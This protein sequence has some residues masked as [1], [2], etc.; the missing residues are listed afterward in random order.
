[1]VT[2]VVDTMRNMSDFNFSEVASNASTLF[3]DS[4]SK[5]IN[6]MTSKMQYQSDQKMSGLEKE[7]S[8]AQTKK[9]NAQKNYET[10]KGNYDKA[11]KNYKKAKK[12]KDKSKYSSEMKKY[13]KQMN[14][15]KKQ[16]NDYKKLVSEQTEFNN[17]YQE[18]SSQMISEFSS[19]LSEYQTKA[20]TLIDDTING[21]TDTYQAKYDALI[22]K[23]DTLIS[24][25]KSAGDLFEISN[26]GIMTVND[27]KEQTQN[28][29]DY[30]DKL[31][32]IKNKVS[33]E[34]FDQIASYDMDQGSAFMDRLLAMS[35][36][37]LKAYS[38]AY[39]EKM[40]VSEESAK[41]IYSKDF[42]N[43]ANDYKNSLDAAFK[44]LPKELETLGQQTMKGFVNGLTK[45]TDYMTKAIQTMVQAMVDQFK[46]DLDIHSPSKVTEGL[47][48]FTGQGF[49]NGLL[50]SIRRVQKDAR[51]FINS[52]TSP[53]GDYT[54]DIGNVRRTVGANNNRGSAP[55]TQ[56]VVNNYN[57]VQNNTSPK[58][59]SAL[60]TY[61]AR[62]QQVNMLKA[63]TT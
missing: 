33:S 49:G 42:D 26:A 24:K 15:Y 62:R 57:L 29:R 12:T 27:I 53:I 7:L 40:R 3:S 39:D 20:Q 46:S 13:Q 56:T 61:R 22:E 58:S 6:Y 36:A 16:T 34:L 4:M 17:A 32:T 35:D 5:Q 50:E 28:I 45:N 11:K 47:G 14:T 48:I 23:Q 54:T 44:D 41:K 9:D 31:Q 55:V 43:V 59:L 25:L 60:D 63:M 19:A 52:V 38:D 1:M 8:S 2:T 18:A 10:A 37:D 21:I 30:T 51:Q